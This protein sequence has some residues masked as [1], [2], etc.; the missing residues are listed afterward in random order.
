MNERP[1][2]RWVAVAS[3][4]SSVAGSTDWKMRWPVP[5]LLVLDV[6]HHPARE[7]ARERRRA[8]D[9]GDAADGRLDLGEAERGGRRGDAERLRGIRHVGAV[10]RGAPATGSACRRPRAR[11]THS[12]SV[13]YAR[14]L[15]RSMRPGATTP[16]TR[17]PRRVVIA[18]GRRGDVVGDPLDDDRRGCRP[19]RGACVRRSASTVS[20]VPSTTSSSW[21]SPEHLPRLRGRCGLRAA[22]SGRSR[23]RA[24]AR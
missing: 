24:T 19:H 21:G 16:S 20:T 8:L 18:A 12:G 5:E 11:P 7:R 4:C 10:R 6:A 9:R 2:A 22:D 14:W 13:L 23:C 17:T 1:S 3:S 15:C